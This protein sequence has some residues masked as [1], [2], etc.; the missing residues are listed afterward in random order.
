MDQR[1]SLMGI[2]DHCCMQLKR[3]KN[4]PQGKWLKSIF[5]QKKK[6]GFD[7]LQN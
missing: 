4:G 6:G 5:Q 7:L 2:I 3:F 1:Q